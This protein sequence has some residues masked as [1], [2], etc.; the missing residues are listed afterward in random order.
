MAEY[1][2]EEWGIKPVDKGVKYVGNYRCHRC[3]TGLTENERG[4]SWRKSIVGYSP[5]VPD[6]TGVDRDCINRNH[7]GGIVV[8]CAFCEALSWFHIKKWYTPDILL[9]DTPDWPKR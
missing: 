6:P 7:D 9:E 2:W 5:Y 8:R 3:S 1:I 4:N